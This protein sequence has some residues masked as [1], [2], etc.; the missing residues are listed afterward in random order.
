MQQ[1]LL[2]LEK[3]LHQ[4]LAFKR[5]TVL[6]GFVT[7]RNVTLVQLN[8]IDNVCQIFE[9][10]VKSFHSD[11]PE[12]H[13]LNGE[14]GKWEIVI[15]K[16]ISCKFRM[17]KSSENTFVQTIRYGTDCKETYKRKDHFWREV[18]SQT[19]SDD[20]RKYRTETCT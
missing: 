6:M 11:E 8:F 13:R 17:F 10:F 7:S 15:Q 2:G 9:D 4:T 3:S 1:R 12:I 18:F 14:M 16:R 20:T 19:T 5:T